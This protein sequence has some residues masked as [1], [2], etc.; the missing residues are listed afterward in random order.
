MGLTRIP[1]NMLRAKGAK[2]ATVLEI[3]SEKVVAVT[4]TDAD[5]SEV[6][7]GVYDA[8]QGT[9]TLTFYNGDQL[10]V[11]GFPTADKIPQGPTGPQGLAGV[12]GKDGTDGKDG[13]TGAQGCDGTSGRD[14]AT[15][16][17]GPQGRQGEIGEQGATGPTG[18]QGATGPTGPTGPR[19]NVGATGA[20][21]AQGAT[22]KAGPKGEDGFMNIYVQ[23]YEPT[24]SEKK[25]GVLWVNP[26]DNI[27]VVTDNPT[28]ID[29]VST[30]LICDS[31]DTNFSAGPV[32]VT[33]TQR[34]KIIQAYRT[35]PNGLGRCPEYDGYIFWMNLLT[36]ATSPDGVAHTMDDVV[37]Q[38]HE[39][40]TR[41][42]MDPLAQSIVDSGCIAAAN[43]LIGEGNYKTATF[44]RGSGKKCLITYEGQG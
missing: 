37:Q 39:A 8:T 40:G 43:V 1:T 2:D 7:D 35:I 6:E 19:G 26:D 11:T 32:G 30:D 36:A 28:E 17:R 3:E 44:I 42:E 4:P 29:E 41:N 18:P 33:D 12:D 23:T 34:R 21:G 24:A 25:D 15:G 9:L 10:K 22:G 13:S 16:A 5:V 14:G 31:T 20:R 38:I 27:C